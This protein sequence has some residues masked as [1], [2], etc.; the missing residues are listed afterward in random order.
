MPRHLHLRLA[1]ADLFLDRFRLFLDLVWPFFDP[2]LLK[3]RFRGLLHQL[4]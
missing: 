1:F 3:N 4:F 2:L